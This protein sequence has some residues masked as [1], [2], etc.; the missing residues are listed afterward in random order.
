LRDLSANKFIDSGF[1]TPMLSVAVTSNS[2]KRVEK[3]EFAKS[4]N[5]YIARRENEPALY[6]LDAKSVNDI[7]EASNNI[8]QTAS[9]PKK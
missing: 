9:A 1:A 6:E 3:V 7:L 5:G 4:A 8:K 2:G